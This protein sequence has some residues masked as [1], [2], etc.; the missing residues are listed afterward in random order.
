MRAPARYFTAKQYS[1]SELFTAA[2][3]KLFH[4]DY[5]LP[6]FYSLLTIL[7]EYAS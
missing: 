2:I 1:S 4:H 5:F 7:L 3:A 6:L